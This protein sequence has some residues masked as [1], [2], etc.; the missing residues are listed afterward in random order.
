MDPHQWPPHTH[1]EFSC[2][3][4]CGLRQKTCSPIMLGANGLQ[5]KSHHGPQWKVTSLSTLSVWI[6]LHLLLSLH[7]LLNSFTL[8]LFAPWFF[9]Q[10]CVTLVW[11]VLDCWLSAHLPKLDPSPTAPSEA[12]ITL[13]NLLGQHTHTTQY[14]CSR[15]IGILHT[16]VG[17]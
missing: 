5:L 4:T 6:K 12:Q 13:F 16:G 10:I 9:L 2:W 3:W 11:S 17:Q 15:S 14:S 7:S 1:T 8:N